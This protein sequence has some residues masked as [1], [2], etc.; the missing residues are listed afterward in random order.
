M[1]YTIYSGKSPQPKEYR[2]VGKT[3]N[4]AQMNKIVDNLRKRGENV[5]VLTSQPCIPTYASHY[6]A[7]K[8]PEENE[9]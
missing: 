2:Y 7:Y 6:L 9:Q 3:Q 5:L 4:T 1:E 8:M